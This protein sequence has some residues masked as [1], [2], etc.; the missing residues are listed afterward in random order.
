MLSSPLDL[1]CRST[2]PDPEICIQMFDDAS[3]SRVYKPLHLAGD[4]S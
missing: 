3:G 4:R 1:I 2:T